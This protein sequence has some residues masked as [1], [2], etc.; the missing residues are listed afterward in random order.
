MLCGQPVDGRL[1]ALFYVA[2]TQ[3]GLLL[4]N[5]VK[6]I[7]GS[8]NS[9]SVWFDYWVGDGPLV[10]GAESNSLIY[11]NK[12]LLVKDLILNGSWHISENLGL[13]YL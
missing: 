1:E 7:M 11:L 3:M 10:N 4:K 13:L 6:W 12:N 8:G 2:W 5:D 9:I